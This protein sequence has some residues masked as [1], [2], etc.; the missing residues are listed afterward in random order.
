MYNIKRD[1]QIKKFSAYGF[2][3]N[4]K[5]F[6]PYLILFLMD[7]EINL[8]E[9]GILFAIKEMIIYIFEVPSGI[10]ADAYGRKKELMMCFTFYMISFV[11]FFFTKHFITAMFAMVFFGLGEAFRSGTHKAMIYTYLEIND[12]SSYKAEVYGRTRSFSLIGSAI[13]AVLAV[14]IVLMIPSN[15]YIF[16]ISIIP[17]I[18]DMILILSYPEVLNGPM[19]KTHDNFFKMMIGQLK[20]IVTHKELRWLLIRSSGFEG[21]FKS[22]KDYIQPI[23]SGLLLV[24]GIT[25][26]K[27]I[28]QEDQL[29][30]L[31]GVSYGLIYLVGAVASRQAHL[32]KRLKS[33]AEILTVIQIGLIASCILMFPAIENNLS[34]LV[35][36]LFL[37][38]YVLRDIRKPLFLEVVDDHMDASKRATVLSVESQLKALFTIILAPTVGYIAD[39]FSVGAG[40]MALAGFLLFIN[41]FYHMKVVMTSKTKY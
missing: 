4:L 34:F 13:S 2:L 40:F 41:I 9:I 10:I 37:V 33:S 6:E 11:F 36:F 28:S 21:V 19:I 24:S 38:M 35:I 14:V 8:F 1:I 3:K 5:F 23:L 39:H 31:L 32:L 22:I 20:G 30:I 12:L 17:Y 25:L 27:G 15:K 26:F 18:L 16:L 29:K 7:M